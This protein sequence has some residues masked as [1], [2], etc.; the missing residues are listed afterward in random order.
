MLTSTFVG[1]AR[2]R[3]LQYSYFLRYYQ[4]LTPSV[5]YHSNRN[6]RNHR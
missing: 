4:I 5:D 1:F 6:P 2:L 3:Q